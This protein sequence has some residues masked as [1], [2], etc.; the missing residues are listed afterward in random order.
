[1]SCL[2]E[3]THGFTWGDN[4][5]L[6]LGFSMVAS[7]N[8]EGWGCI[9]SNG[10]IRHQETKAQFRRFLFGDW[11]EPQ[12]KHFLRAEVFATILKWGPLLAMLP[13]DSF[14]ASP[15]HPWW[16]GQN[17]ALGHAKEYAHVVK[18]FAPLAP[19]LVPSGIMFFGRLFQ[20]CRFFTSQF[21]LPFVLIL[22]WT[23]N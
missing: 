12:A 6:K 4:L 14:S 10:M 2:R 21:C 7:A 19:A 5:A 1:M 3:S 20:L 9:C 8:W 16:L 15:R 13:L 11:E 18:A 17:L 22:W 23:F